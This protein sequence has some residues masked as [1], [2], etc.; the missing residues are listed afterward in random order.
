V[1]TSIFLAKLIG[2]V[3]LVMGAGMILNARAFR[4]IFEEM[5]RNRAF[6]VLGGLLT[7]P[8]GLAIV[9]THNVWVANWP[10]LITVI[11]WL[12]AISGALRL[13]APQDAIRF[14]RR[15][16]DQP[17]GVFVGAAIWVALGAV[18]C[19]FGYLQ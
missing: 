19:F 5:I 15:M 2:P 16:Y 7:M 17:N 8:A 13:L 1:N 4:P 3:L 9:L 6:V 12:T 14:G 10:V 11:G 18:L